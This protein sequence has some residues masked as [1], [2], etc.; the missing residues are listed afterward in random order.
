L[1]ESLR[2]TLI[3]YDS[4]LSQEGGALFFLSEKTREMVLSLSDANYWVTRWYNSTSPDYEFTDTDL[5]NIREYASTLEKE[6]LT[7]IEICAEFI[8]CL[9]NDTDVQNAIDNRITNIVNEAEARLLERMN[10]LFN[11]AVTPP[12]GGNCNDKLF[13]CIKQ[14]LQYM[15]SKNL[16]WLESIS[17][18]ILNN[19]VEF[20]D[21]VSAITV[22][23][24]LSVDAITGF[25]N[26]VADN[27]LDA[28][29]SVSTVELLDIVACDIFCMVKDTCTVDLQDIHGYFLDRVIS[30]LPAFELVDFISFCSQ[31][32]N[33]GAGVPDRLVFDAIML[34]TTTTALTLDSL[35]GG[36]IKKIGGGSDLYTHMKSYSN[37]SDADW[38]TLCECATDAKTITVY[39]KGYQINGATLVVVNPSIDGFYSIDCYIGDEI[40]LVCN[41]SAV[42]VGSCSTS[43]EQ[44]VTITYL[45]VAS[46]ETPNFR[47]NG[48]CNVITTFAV[49][50]TLVNGQAEVYGLSAM[51]FTVDA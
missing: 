36:A 31:I 20:T 28:Y 17:A 34:S 38:A 49:S 35:L 50:D 11:L 42:A 6:I 19:I 27:L 21:V 24:E 43:T 8:N 47:E 41:G 12:D 1:V 5:A 14:T 32:I 2:A 15:D 10:Q 26:W 37:D 40:T 25:V 3:P 30:A 46:G 9:E 45:S 39:G 7:M 51:S 29:P 18:S 44:T 22:L 13:A 48:T 33:I 16:D 23:D 4:V